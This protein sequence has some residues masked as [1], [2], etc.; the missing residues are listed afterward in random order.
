MM[1]D[2]RAAAQMGV[3][4]TC[5]RYSML[6]ERLCRYCGKLHTSR[7]PI[8]FRDRT[9]GE[10]G[11]I[12]GF[13]AESGGLIPMTHRGKIVT[14]SDW[15]AITEGVAKFYENI[16]PVDIQKYNK[17]ISTILKKSAFPS[18]KEAVYGYIYLLRSANGYYKI[19][20]TK[21]MGMRLVAIQRSFPIE[22]KLVHCFKSQDYVAAE[23]YLH[24]RYGEYR[25]DR[26]EWFTLPDWAVEY[27]RDIK[28]YGVDHHLPQQSPTT[29]R[30][31]DDPS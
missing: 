27:I 18:K 28:D 14:V 16:T 21:G 26:T 5:F 12:L 6:V 20:R 4:E 11:D 31:T 15:I 8:G 2:T 23:A 1:E 9:N 29:K 22:I 7:K 24:D 30:I 10:V 19:G 25:P 13:K 17:R 3:C